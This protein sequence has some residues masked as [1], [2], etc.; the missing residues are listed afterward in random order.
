[1]KPGKRPPGDP[2][3]ERLPVGHPEI[4]PQLAVKGVR[5]VTGQ[6]VY[7]TVTRSHPEL[8][9]RFVLMTGGACSRWAED[10]LAGYR[11]VQ[12][13]KPFTTDEVEQVL[14]LVG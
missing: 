1:M 6:V 14:E 12:L 9:A 11:G 4:T 8:A 2:A 7:E 5:E 13:D 3:L 10:F